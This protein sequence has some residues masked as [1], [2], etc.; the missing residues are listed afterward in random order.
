MLHVLACHGKWE[1]VV[2]SA[3]KSS[4]ARALSHQ[5]C[6]SNYKD[7]CSLSSLVNF[8]ILTHEHQPEKCLGGPP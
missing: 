4:D 8:N 1:A 7:T 3:K 2:C 5:G 6:P